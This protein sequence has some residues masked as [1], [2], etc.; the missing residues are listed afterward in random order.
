MCQ[1]T[2]R[3]RCSLQIA[4]ERGKMG[5]HRSGRFSRLDSQPASQPGD[6]RPARCLCADVSPSGRGG[7]RGCLLNK[8]TR[9]GCSGADGSRFSVLPEHGALLSQQQQRQQQ[10]LLRTSTRSHNKVPPR[11]PVY[12]FVRKDCCCSHKRTNTNTPALA[13]EG[14][15]RCSSDNTTAPLLLLPPLLPCSLLAQCTA[16]TAFGA[17]P[18]QCK[19]RLSFR[20][21]IRLWKRKGSNIEP[22]SGRDSRRDSEQ[23]L[24]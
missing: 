7:F 2:S 20:M 15:E 9:Y 23:K 1:L 17:F 13:F 4:V 6:C 11:E 16:L 21:N 3:S 24:L 18:K 8:A 12:V 5:F 10:R 14:E 22:A 19:A